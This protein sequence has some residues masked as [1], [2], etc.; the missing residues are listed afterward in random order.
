MKKLFTLLCSIAVLFSMTACSSNS[1]E[2][3][4]LDALETSINKIVEMKTASYS[5]TVDATVGEENA[6][7]YLHGGY[8]AD[9]A[10]PSFTAVIDLESQDT[11]ME[12]FMGLYMK[13]NIMYMDMEMMGMKQKTTMEE[14]E[15]SGLM[16]EDLED[17]QNFKMNK[18]EIKPYLKK[19]SLKDQTLTLELD[20]AKLTE[21]VKDKGST[22][23]LT[24]STA[25]ATYS[26]FNL[27][28]TLKDDFMTKAIIDF[29]GTQKNA[30][31]SEDETLS[32]TMT[33]EFTDINTGKALVFPDFSDYIDSAETN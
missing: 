11:K 27:T 1:V 30:T 16:P 20:P 6:K 15:D 12:N 29:E 13:D 19:A 32:G 3:E 28:V 14:A 23:G 21:S 22:T 8:L 18:E 33:L 24:S 26:K 25:D 5:L 17:I 9:T 31:T 2:D 7:V 4:A 10:K